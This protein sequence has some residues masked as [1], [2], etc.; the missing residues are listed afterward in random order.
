MINK[1]REQRAVKF[2]VIVTPED[3]EANAEFVRLADQYVLAPGGANH[4]NYAN[5]EFIASVARNKQVH[6]VW[7]G[8]GHASENP[9]LPDLLDRAGIMFLG[10]SAGAMRALGDKISSCI[11]AQSAQLPTLAWSGSGITCDGGVVTEQ[12]YQ[13]AACN[14]LERGLA[15]AAQI[16][17]PVMIK[18]LRD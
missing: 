16:G 3:L 9:K 13:R 5:C 1:V 18:G 8:W 12:H 17:Y 15:A 11:V 14:T 7:A 2:V 10:P 6:A 4:N